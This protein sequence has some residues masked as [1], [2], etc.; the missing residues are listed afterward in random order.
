M[1]LMFWEMFPKAK[2]KLTKQQ[3]QFFNDMF[4]LVMT[5]VDTSHVTTIPAR[6]GIGKSTF[7]KVLTSLLITDEA[8]RMQPTGM[9]VITDSIE[10]LKDWGNILDIKEQLRNVEA[11]N[12][13]FGFMSQNFDKDLFNRRVSILTSENCFVEQMIEQKYKPIVMLT[14]QRYFRMD[15]QKREE[16]FH[17]KWGG[18]DYE[19]KII[20]CDEKPYFS[21]ILD[22]GIKNVNDISTALKD[23][24]TDKV[25]E[26]KWVCNQFEK[27][28][29]Y[30][31]NTLEEKED[32]RKDKNIYL[33]HRPD[34]HSITESGEDDK[35]FKIISDNINSLYPL[36]NDILRDLNLIKI[37]LSSGAWFISK[38]IKDK[39]SGN[40]YQK[41]FECIVDHEDAF[42][43]KSS[44]KCFVFDATADIDPAYKNLKYIAPI[45]NSDIYCSPINLT[46][47]VIDEMTSKSRMNNPYE[48]NKIIGRVIKHMD[49]SG[50]DKESTVVLSYK[51]VENKF[52][53]YRYHGH[54]GA[55]KGSND[56][57]ELSKM[58]HVGLFRKP[59]LTYFIEFCA[60]YPEYMQEIQ[61]MSEQESM[62]YLD[63]ISTMK[64]AEVKEPL[65]QYI[66]QS[67][68]TDF[69]Q[70]VFRLAIRNYGTKE[71]AAVHLFYHANNNQSEKTEYELIL[72]SIKRRFERYKNV[73][74]IPIGKTQD[75]QID[76]IM[77]RK[78][79]KKSYAQMIMEWITSLEVGN[80]FKV[81]DLLAALNLS[82]S[83]F[84]KAKQN[85]QELAN[86]LNAMKDPDHKRIFIKK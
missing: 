60:I 61:R 81:S 65:R 67:L 12:E 43:L 72:E 63:K 34:R 53:N 31:I 27:F 56:F 20:L 85:N 83:Q 10:R 58:A 17:F 15:E 78:N 82:N 18:K 6:C 16:L 69:E 35:F 55:L 66:A 70:N 38:K 44:R 57:R 25:E 62:E 30:F 39:E 36:Y 33:Y 29:E 5:D 28:R 11:L 54:F 22:I 32:L 84:Q 21:E 51:A 74:I 1:N 13:D 52:S 68:V 79:A 49:N 7:V 46:I 77:D 41:C 45:Q 48:S 42:Y 14:T 37:I 9:V 23:G 86:I 76:K 71:P 26:K 3:E 50:L 64:V 24:L 8:M 4:E 73:S 47:T 2:E 59:T 19:R 80:S 40:K 75:A